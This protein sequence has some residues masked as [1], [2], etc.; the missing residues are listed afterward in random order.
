ML[1]RGPVTHQYYPAPMT[2]IELPGAVRVTTKGQSGATAQNVIQTWAVARPVSSPNPNGA[3]FYVQGDAA[4]PLYR[5]GVVPLRP[6]K[7]R[8]E[9]DPS[10]PETWQRDYRFT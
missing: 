9:M 6:A 8:V 5:G 4:N 10:N 7:P 2:T 1:T 3:P